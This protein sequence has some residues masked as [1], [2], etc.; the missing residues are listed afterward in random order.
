MVATPLRVAQYGFYA[1]LDPSKIVSGR[2]AIYARTRR[3]RI[4]EAGRLIAFYLLNLF[5]YAVP[6]TFAGFGGGS[7]AGDPPALVETIAATV[8]TEPAATW[9][10]LSALLQNC[11]FLLLFSVLTFG[12]FH[13]AIWATRNSKGY[14]QSIH[15]VVYSTGIYLAAI[16]SFTWYLTTS[17]TIV[18]AEEWLIWVQ[19][20]F[21][22]TIIDVVGADLQLPAGRPDPV[23]MTGVT[24]SGAL[25]LAGLFVATGYYLYSL[26]LGA[27]IN[28]ASNRFTA[29][30]AVG[31]VV[32]SPVLFVLGSVL[33]ALYGDVGIAAAFHAMIQL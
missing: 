22:Y 4:R 1:V 23:D 20:E 3:D 19:A 9:Q 27:R 15:T 25:A 7:E 8:G 14:L 2:S 33:T 32:I 24:Q 11:S 31:F 26:Y 30:L 13:F 21:V 17:P 29:L 16:F 28:H 12:T 6:L 18:V 10:Y 5:L